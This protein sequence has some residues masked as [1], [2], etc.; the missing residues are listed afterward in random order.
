M[1][2]ST[3]GI[4]LSF[5]LY[6]AAVLL[7]GWLAYRRTATISDFV[8]GGRRLGSGV[9]ALSAS[10]S[11]M[12]GWL[13]LGLPGLAYASGISSLWLAG[14]LLLGTWLNWRLLAARVRVFTEHYGD[15]LTLPEYLA[16]RFEDRS[17]LL[18]ASQ[19]SLSCCSS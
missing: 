10:A 3:A 5:A 8:L 11:D 12:S 17:G 2:A 1:T 6:F 13:L 16:N 4:S 18:R 15:A 19:P 7:I 14:G 9:A